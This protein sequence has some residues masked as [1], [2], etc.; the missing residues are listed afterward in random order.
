MM[1]ICEHIYSISQGTIKFDKSLSEFAVF[2]LHV[3]NDHLLLQA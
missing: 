1:M 3:V 2:G